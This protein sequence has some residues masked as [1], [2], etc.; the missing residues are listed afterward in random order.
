MCH[1]WTIYS[2]GILFSE[3]S[4]TLGIHAVV[5]KLRVQKQRFFGRENKSDDIILSHNNDD[6]DL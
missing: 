4:D 6:D 1:L 5:C 2:I 3:A